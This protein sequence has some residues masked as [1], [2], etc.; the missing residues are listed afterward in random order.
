LVPTF[1]GYKKRKGKYKEKGKLKK[2]KKS[3]TKI[4]KG[5][6]SKPHAFVFF[7]LP[8]VPG[9]VTH[10]GSPLRTPQPCYSRFLVPFSFAPSCLSCFFPLFY[11][12]FALVSS[13][14]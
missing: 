14:V 3:N 6:R 9:Q 5:N 11:T 10:G 2:V 7:F 12:V 8:F 4:K 1:P 13:N